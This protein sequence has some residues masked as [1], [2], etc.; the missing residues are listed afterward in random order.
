LAV[1]EG[2]GVETV[3]AHGSQYAW[4]RKQAGV[5]ASG[6]VRIGERVLPLRG[7]AVVDDS[8]GYHG[9]HTAWRWSA[10]VGTARDGAEVGWNLVEGIN[11]PARASER[12]VWVNG[13]AHEADP[14]S[15]APDLSRVGNLR[16]RAEAR[17]VRR[18]NLL[19]LRSDYEQPFGTFTGTLPGGIELASGLGV[20]EHH[21]VRW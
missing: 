15:F 4:T 8:A 12:T 2:A 17:R 1:A 20:M 14:V 19:V 6:S 21:D 10:G 9:R 7:R 5:A 11:D 16:F 18:D 13:V 3:C